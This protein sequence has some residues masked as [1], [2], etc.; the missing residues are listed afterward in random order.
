MRRGEWLFRAVVSTAL[1]YEAV[2]LQTSNLPTITAFS[3]RYPVT[4]ALVV[5]WLVHHFRTP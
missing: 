2:A 4:K 1:A 5:G 3:H